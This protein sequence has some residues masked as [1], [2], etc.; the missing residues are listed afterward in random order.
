MKVLF[1]IFLIILKLYVKIS[2]DNSRFAK[3]ISGGNVEFPLE[4][5]KEAFNYYSCGEENGT[6]DL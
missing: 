3:V 5:F 4:V 1:K 6:H 2:G